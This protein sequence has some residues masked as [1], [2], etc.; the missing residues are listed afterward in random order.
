MFSTLM[1]IIDEKESAEK[2][3]N[4][5][6]HD[7]SVTILTSEEPEETIS[8]V[9]SFEPDLILL[10]TSFNELDG[11]DLCRRLREISNLTRPVIVLLSDDKEEPHL[12][13]KGFMLGADDNL[14]KNLSP[15]EFSIRLYAHIRR[16]IEELSDHNTKLPGATLINTNLKR[17]INSDEPWALLIL[18]LSHLKPYNDTYGCLAGNQLIKAFVAIVKANTEQDDFFGHIGNE[19]FALITKPLIVEPMA[20]SICKTIDQI[21]P[22]FYAPFEAERG[23][24]IVSDEGKASRRVPL[25]SVHIGII[26]S[27]NRTIDN[28]QTAMSIANGLKD[29]ARQQLGSG[30][31]LDRP[32][33]KGTEHIKQA[34]DK[35]YIVV[36]ES[37]AALAYLLTTTLEMQGYAVDASTSKDEAIKL[38]DNKQPDLVLIDAVIPGDDGW[39]ICNYI[40]SN[41]LL[42]ATKIIMA[43]ILH[44]KEKA[45]SAGAD[46][47]I[48]KPYDLMSLHK[49]INKL[50]SDSY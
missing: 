49:W 12:R 30:W 11:Y 4:S 20:E 17:R 47:Y 16:H 27:L 42:T 37:D 5:L 44:D 15:E 26:T 13:I 45:F 33:I 35:K 46:V 39:G 41:N 19:D 28:Y 24:T 1:L 10:S 7:P 48:P 6:Q 18:N 3:K 50:V 14:S 36:V 40:K 23:F 22:R 31:L 25:V 29:L 34:R 32:L 9:E 21:V 38:I 2:L 8:I 43:T